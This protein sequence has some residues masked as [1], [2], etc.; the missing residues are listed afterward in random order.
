MRRYSS[1]CIGQSQRLNLGVTSGLTEEL[2][3]EAGRHINSFDLHMTLQAAS[4]WKVVKIDDLEGA[5]TTTA[6]S[7]LR[8]YS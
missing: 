6:A 2:F 5:D 8:E 1:I 4:G 7:I 3:S